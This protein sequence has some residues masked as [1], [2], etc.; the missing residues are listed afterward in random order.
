MIVH[1]NH[2]Q[3]GQATA[4]GGLVGTLFGLVEEGRV[5]PRLLPHLRV[6]L[7]WIQYRQNFREAVTVRRATD[8]RGDPLPLAEVAV[9]LRQVRPETLREELGACR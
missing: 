7:D 9:D 3:R 4:A 5:A 2:L 8:S 6:H 1:I